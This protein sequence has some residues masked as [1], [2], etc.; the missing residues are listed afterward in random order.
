MY[1]KRHKK[2]R[3]ILKP[4]I[5]RFNMDTSTKAYSINGA[6]YFLFR[7]NERVFGLACNIESGDDGIRMFL[8]KKAGLYELGKDIVEE[9]RADIT[10]HLPL[11]DGRY[12]V[13]KAVEIARN[14]GRIFVSDFVSLSVN[15]DELD[16]T[17]THIIAHPV[18]FRR[19]I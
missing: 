14:A 2:L 3:K 15:S 6:P 7:L 17:S 4:Q 16:R 1:N 19:I 10:V 5:C 12:D 9:E 18:F 13:V 8:D 11:V